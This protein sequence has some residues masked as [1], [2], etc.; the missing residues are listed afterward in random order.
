MTVSGH[1]KSTLFDK[2]SSHK[3]DKTG[4]T[5]LYVQADKENQ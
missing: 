1:T 5:G 2:Q 3:E 4:Q